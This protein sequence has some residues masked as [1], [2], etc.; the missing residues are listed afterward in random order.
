VRAALALSPLR[1]ELE[2]T[3]AKLLALSESRLHLATEATGIGICEM[4]PETERISCSESCSALLGLPPRAP[5]TNE[6]FLSALHPDDRE[7]LRVAV[8]RALDPAGDGAYAA[9]YRT[10]GLHDGVKRWIA[11]NGRAFF[12]ARRAVRFV[13]T[14]LD[15]TERVELMAREQKAR[16][17]AEGANR[18]KDEFLATVSHELR[19]PLTSISGWASILAAKPYDLPMIAKGIEIIGRNAKVQTRIVD[20][21]LDVS[22]IVTGR[23][24]IEQ[25]SVDFDAVV[26]EAIEEA[27]PS[28]VAKGIGLRYRHE[29]GPCNLVG[30]PVRLGQIVWNLLS[31]AVKFTPHGGR[32]DVELSRT[33]AEA[34]LRV[35]DDGEGIDPTLLPHVFE[36]FLQADSSITRR[37]GGLG[38]GL[39]IVRELVKLHGGETSAESEGKGRGSTLTV[40]LPI[41]TDPTMTLQ[42]AGAGP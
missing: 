13:G 34:R 42:V 30:D 39:S 23:L 8:Q 20:D 5:A 22:R 28:A 18:L 1:R 25:K 12:E 16:A 11:A 21:I 14:V 9:E 7:P 27:M 29:H 40:T 33:H 26:K 4:D 17:L 19:T 2:V 41:V 15:V 36:R 38:L 31:N 3:Q 6:D 32:I 10:L 24:H 37:H 35:V